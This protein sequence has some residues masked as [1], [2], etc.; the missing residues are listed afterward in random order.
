VSRVLNGS[1]KVRESTRERILAEAARLNYTPHHAARALATR[2]TRTI[3]VVL[4]TI[5]SSILARVIGGLESTVRR[6][7]YALVTASTGFDQAVEARHGQDL[8]GLG[9]EALVVWGLEHDEALLRAA[10]GRGVPI[11]C[12]SVFEPDCPLPTIGSDNRAMGATAMHHL[13]DRGHEHIALVSGPLSGNDRARMRL[14]GALEVHPDRSKLPHL[15]TSLSVE[16]G[17]RA[18]RELATMK[19]RPTAM[20]CV[21]DVPAMGALFEAP[22]QGLRVPDDLSVVGLDYFD[23]APH[24]EPTLT[25]VHVPSDELGRAL[26]EAVVR[27]LDEGKP[28][29]SIEV[30]ARLLERS[31]T[32]R[33]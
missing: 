16:G 8:I 31:S 20:L 25:A 24:I 23:W 18:V 27:Y 32:A 2:R 15:E 7:G 3:G 14:A 11:V 33:R 26:G 28:I 1:S 22:R 12:A 13:L 6:H 9:A 21:S 4:P 10:Q 30:K 19:P 5:E 29:D 17:V